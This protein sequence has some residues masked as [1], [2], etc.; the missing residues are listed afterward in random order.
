[1]F[2]RKLIQKLAGSMHS[3]DIQK[4]HKCAVCAKS[5]Q[6]SISEKV[7]ITLRKICVA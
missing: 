3:S 4:Q 2:S 5:A 6:D 1:M 7:A